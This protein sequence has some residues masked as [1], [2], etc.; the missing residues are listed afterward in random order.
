MERMDELRRPEENTRLL[1]RVVCGASGVVVAAVLAY[2]VATA[3]LA[4]GGLSVAGRALVDSGSPLPGFP[5]PAAYLGVA[6]VTFFYSGLRL[7]EGRVARLSQT[8]LASIQLVAIVAALG[9]AYGLLYSFVLWGSYS[10]VQVLYDHLPPGST[11]LASPA[12]APWGVVLGTWGF[13]AVFAIGAYSAYYLRRIHQ[14][15]RGGGAP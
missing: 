8:K 12:P 2:A 11:L 5:P 15:P 3:A 1:Y 9:S 10:S 7:W 4:G 14:V 13:A 6:S